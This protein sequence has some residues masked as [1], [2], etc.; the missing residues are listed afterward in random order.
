MLTSCNLHVII[1]VIVFSMLC[2]FF[3]DCIFGS[4]SCVNCVSKL[5]KDLQEETKAT[6]AL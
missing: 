3:S 2:T 1:A 4:P 6:F 5:G